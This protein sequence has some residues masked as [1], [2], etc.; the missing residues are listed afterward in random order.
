MVFIRLSN[1][2][3]PAPHF[4]VRRRGNLVMSSI[5]VRY[6]LVTGEDEI[7]RLSYARFDRLCSNPPKDNIKDFAGQRV[8]WVEIVVELENRKPTKILN[9]N[10][11]YLLFKNEG[12]PDVDRFTNDAAVVINAG[13]P[14][15]VVGG[16]P[17]NV[18][19]AQKVFSKK[20]R[21]HQVW[22]KPNTILERKIMDAA[23]DQFKYRKL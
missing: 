4:H 9:V 10:Y 12:Y 23:I 11:G 22:W 8:R 17:D 1:F 14:D 7:I 5:S 19:N 18:I 15:F 6:F 2:H 3:F 21:D 16:E 20:C 13:F